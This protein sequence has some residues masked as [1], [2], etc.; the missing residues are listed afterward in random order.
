MSRD[1]EPIGY[2]VRPGQ[3]EGDWQGVVLYGLDKDMW[4]H[5]YPSTTTVRRSRAAV[6]KAAKRIFEREH[7]DWEWRN[8]QPTRTFLKGDT[9]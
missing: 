5:F 6:E 2:E 9:K 3:V 4:S 7:K 1:Y 8:Q